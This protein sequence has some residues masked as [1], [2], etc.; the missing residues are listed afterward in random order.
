MKAV[1]V[2]LLI[3][4]VLRIESIHGAIRKCHFASSVLSVMGSVINCNFQRFGEQASNQ[5]DAIMQSCLVH[6]NMRIIASGTMI[7]CGNL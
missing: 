6:M 1:S 2:F 3:G 7:E 4:V 5:I